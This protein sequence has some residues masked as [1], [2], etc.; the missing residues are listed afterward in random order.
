MDNLVCGGCSVKEIIQ[1]RRCIL[2]KDINI[3]CHLKLEIALAISASTD[4]KYNS[5]NSAGQ[6]LIMN[7]IYLADFSRHLKLEIVLAISTLNGRNIETNNSA[8][9]SVKIALVKS[10]YVYC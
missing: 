6:G 2:S 5:N 3:F 8:A 7:L 9:Q 4:E 10:L 1:V